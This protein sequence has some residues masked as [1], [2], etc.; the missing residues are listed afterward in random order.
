MEH[1]LYDL[2][3]LQE[4]AQDDQDFVNDMIVLFVENVTDDITKIYSLRPF[5]EWKT[6]TVPVHRARRQQPGRLRRFFET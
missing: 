2:S 3:K 5:E 4:M 1:K 6:E